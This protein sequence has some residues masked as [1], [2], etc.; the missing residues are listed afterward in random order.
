MKK[1]LSLILISSVL[2]IPLNNI[3][4][5][6]NDN[7]I[8]SIVQIRCITDEGSWQGSGVIISSDGYVM[9]NKHV[10]SSDTTIYTGC[11]IGITTSESSSAQFLYTADTIIAATGVDLAL[12]KIKSDKKD[13]NYTPVK[14][15]TLPKSGTDIQALGYPGMGGSSITYTRGY[16]SGVIGSQE[17]LGNFFIKADINIDAGNSGGGAFTNDNE[18]LGITSAIL[19]GK[20]NVLGLIIPTVLIKDFL[21]VNSYENL[22]NAEKTTE[23]QV[24][25]Y[26]YGQSETN[27]NLNIPPDG[28]LVRAD[29]SL[30]TDC[31]TCPPTVY[32]IDD[33]YK[34]GIGAFAEMT[35]A[36]CG[37]KWEDVVVVDASIIESIPTGKDFSNFSLHEEDF[38]HSYKVGECW[39]S[40]DQRV[41]RKFPNGTLLQVEFKY[42]P[43]FSTHTIYLLEN[44][45]KRAF[46][47]REVF[48][49]LGY[50]F[51][52]GEQGGWES[53][54]TSVSE[55]EF[56][57]YVIGE[58]I[59]LSNP[60]D[61]TQ[62]ISEG[63]IIRAI[64]GI[65]I[66]IV[67]Y[68]G[69]KKFKRLV[70]N[71][72]V[73]N[74]YGHL[75]WGDVMNVSQAV[76]D[77]FTTSE[78]V[79]AV[80]DDKIY[81]LYAQGDTGQKRMIKNNSVLTR[82]GLDLDSI[83]EINSFDRESYIAGIDLE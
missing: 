17:D 11:S 24:K 48:E 62:N 35:F 73:F 82:L 58:N 54:I 51:N 74:N 83:Y 10:V 23:G 53:N 50:K 49:A 59:T 18:L 14:L 75:R 19:Q 44:G 36:N 32:L 4:A 3:K 60:P 41:I 13:F 47:S 7:T 40:K 42:W 68:V 72:S 29:R 64:N 78:L 66:Y 57:Q 63:A 15:Y 6:V 25:F 56:Y 34:R 55:E 20:Y 43:N 81:R 61:I 46:N 39:V 76:L 1:A 65:D 8:K 38:P 69:T 22:I 31:P 30:R 12:L 21:S 2:V 71:P 37:W 70:L 33:G 77:E 67:K 16:V 28:S 79:R 45:K 26:D 27:N 9:T 52:K 80:G 5:T